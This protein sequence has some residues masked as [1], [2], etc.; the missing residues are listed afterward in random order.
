MEKLVGKLQSNPMRVQFERS[1]RG[2]TDYGRRRGTEYPINHIP[3]RSLCIYTA[4]ALHL[5]YQCGLLH[6]PI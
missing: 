6:A 1:S 4:W 3:N 2:V 5:P